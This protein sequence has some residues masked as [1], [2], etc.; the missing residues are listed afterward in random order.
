MIAQRWH[1]L[2]SRFTADVGI[3]AVFIAAF[4]T[5]FSWLAIQRL[6]TFHS[7]YDLGEHQQVLWNT[8]HGYWFYYTST[9]M[10]LHHFSQHADPL[11]ILI[12]PLYLLHKGPETIL[13][14]QAT[15]VA[16]GGIPVFLLAREKL[17][18]RVFGMTLLLLYLLFPGTEIITVSDFHPPVLAMSFLMAAFYF[19]EKKRDSWFVVFIV[20]AMAAKEQIPLVVFFMGV[21]AIIRHRKWMLGLT[22][23]ILSAAWFWADMYWLIPMYSV[24]HEQL[25]LHFYAD[26]GST[27]LEIV[28]RVLARPQLVVAS[29]W[30]PEKID[31]LIK[32][33]APFGF[34][35]LIG[36]PILLI[37]T[38]AF[39]INLLS[40]NP[41]MFTADRGHYIADY[42]PWLVWGTL[43]GAYFLQKIARKITTSFIPIEVWQAKGERLFVSGLS[44][45]LLVVGLSWQ[46][47]YGLTPLSVSQPQWHSTERYDISQALVRQIPD[48][49]V[50][51]AQIPL[52]AFISTR[53]TAYVFPY[54]AESDYIFLDVTA[55][56]TPLHPN[57]FR[58][59]VRKLLADGQFGV[60]RA[61]DGFIV[62]KRGEP[63]TTLPDAFFDF[64]R[65]TDPQPEIPLD[66]QFG[67][68]LRLVGADVLDNPLW[69]ETQ[70]RLYW[71]ALK[72]IDEP[73]RLYPFFINPNG[74]TIEDTSLRP[75]ATQLWYPPEQWKA[76]ET[77]VS[78]TLPW[79]LG[80]EWSLAVGVLRGENW[81]DWSRRLPVAAAAGLRRFDAGTWVRAASFARQGRKLVP[82]AAA[83]ADLHPPNIA[84]FNFDNKMELRGYAAE[85]SGDTLNVT[86]FWRASAAMA[87]DYTVFVHLLDANGAV[88][89]QHDGQPTWQLP[90]PTSTWQ[91]GETLRDN[92]PITL[93]ADLPPGE[94]QLR[95]GVYFWQT[96]ERLPILANGVPVGDS[97]DLGVVRLP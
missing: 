8:L 89:A 28:T 72:P 14:L 23:M 76:G 5:Y 30:Q 71:R 16:L 24:T 21:Y 55:L 41:A 29:L 37:G 77:V 32:L 86:L 45:I 13:I 26:F 74:E 68:A 11:L 4:S 59:A 95:V 54:V 90:M 66:V 49:A 36:F 22:T 60:W 61:D 31:F 46:M 18:S 44:V 15:I 63:N 94:Y 20:L 80:N 85:H 78:E 1:W 87:R 27:P 39:A 42:I 9:G 65:E 96:L 35:P 64:A 52:Y 6:Q 81:S 58:A 88:V 43:F 70:V 82:I 3:A 48:D 92:H 69:A 83:D 53:H 47:N 91:P 33:F 79:P 67:D 2:K 40:S 50:I 93:P 38:P 25:F 84:Q 97:V 75:M 56:T 17:N 10:P 19:L 34:L 7:E 73:L 57:D 51:S 12:A 62:L